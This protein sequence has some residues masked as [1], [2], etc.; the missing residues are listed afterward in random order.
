M[1]ADEHPFL[2]NSLGSKRPTTA[3]KAHIRRLYDVL[4]VCIQRH[5]WQRAQRVWAVLARCREVDWKA[6]WSTSVLLLHEDG[7]RSAG[8]VQSNAERVRFLSVM[9]RQHPDEASLYNQLQ[10]HPAQRLTLFPP[11]MCLPCLSA[12]L[13][14]KSSSY[15]SSKPACTGRLWKNSTCASSSLTPPARGAA[16][17][18]LTDRMRCTRYLPSYPYQD[19]PALHTYAG[20]IAL[21]LAQPSGAI[22]EETMYGSFRNKSPD[23]LG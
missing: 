19:N 8:E 17:L 22:S 5:D 15:A 14:S 18:I 21:F 4:Q 13:Y 12:S 20:L 16:T 10:P 23:V 3:R 9:M 1:P 2:F 11:L 7:D 6:M